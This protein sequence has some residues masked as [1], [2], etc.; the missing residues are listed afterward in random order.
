MLAALL[1]LLRWY[2]LCVHLAIVVKHDAALECRGSQ[3]LV[4]AA[5][6]MV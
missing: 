3:K 6:M 2:Q 1:L 5:L 4:P